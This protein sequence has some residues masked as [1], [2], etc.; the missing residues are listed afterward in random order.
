MARG[1]A[2]SGDPTQSGSLV[3]HLED[4][5]RYGHAPADATRAALVKTWARTMHLALTDIAER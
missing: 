1:P 4:E 5:L 2:R 3:H